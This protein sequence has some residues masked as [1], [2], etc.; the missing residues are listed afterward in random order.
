MHFN[1][2]LTRTV[3][4]SQA[5]AVINCIFQLSYLCKPYEALPA[6]YSDLFYL[7]EPRRNARAVIPSDPSEVTT[8]GVGIL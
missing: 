1:R 3:V 2:S 8:C 5:A 7:V 4:G 6:A